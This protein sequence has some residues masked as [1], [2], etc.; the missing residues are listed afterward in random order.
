MPRPSERYAFRRSS[1]ECKSRISPGSI[2][3][4]RDG[5]ASAAHEGF[6]YIS[7]AGPFENGVENRFRSW[8]ECVTFI[9]SAGI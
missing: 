4:S 7:K 6:P 2:G 8:R 5:N 1:M 9:V 3:A